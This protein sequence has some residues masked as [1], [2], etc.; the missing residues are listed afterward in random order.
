MYD[1]AD[2]LYRKLLQADSLN[3]NYLSAYADIQ[4]KLNKIGIKN[5]AKRYIGELTS[6]KRVMGPVS[7]NLKYGAVL[8]NYKDIAK[9]VDMSPSAVS[10]QLKIL[11]TNKLVKYHK[12]GKEAEY[13][14]DDEHVS[15]ILTMCI[16]HLDH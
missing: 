12:V 10:H 15:T 14:L 4:I 13:A 2:E 3:V 5:V 6:L 16:N 7:F 8:S 11:R 9:E 1:E